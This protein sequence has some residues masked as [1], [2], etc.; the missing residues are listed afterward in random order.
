[1]SEVNKLNLYFDEEALINDLIKALLDG[2]NQVSKELLDLFASK[3]TDPLNW[4]IV[5][6]KGVDIVK[7]YVGSTSWNAFLDNYGTGSLMYKDNPWLN[8]YLQSSF[9][10]KE[11]DNYDRH[12]I[13]R[14]KGEYISPNYKTGDG[15]VWRKGSG[16]V[17]KNGNPLDLET[18]KNK[19]GKPI[20]EAKPP[21]LWLENGMKIIEKRYFDVLSDIIN[22]FDFQNDKYLKGGV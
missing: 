20:M 22:N 19:N 8:E 2:V 10:N 14:P 17:D 9:Y 7:S 4:T 21:H 1:M 3:A 6:E 18:T 13:A 5:I 15:V 11:R 12:I 16:S